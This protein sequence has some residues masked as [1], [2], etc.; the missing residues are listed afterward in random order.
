MAQPLSRINKMKTQISNLR[1]G[2]KNQ[3]LNKDV[4][5]STLPQ[6]TSHNGHAG[7]NNEIANAVWEKVKSENPEI[8]TIE[9]FGSVFELKANWSVSRKSVNYFTEI[10]N[11]FLVANFPIEKSNNETSY[12][13]ISSGT[14]IVVSNGKKSYMT[15]CPSLVKIL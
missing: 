3:V 14:T 5:Y 10:P 2:T 15:I 12:I 1:S 9:I 11:D 4:D 6:S 8:M 7:S 13:N